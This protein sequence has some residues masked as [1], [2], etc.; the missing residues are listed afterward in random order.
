MLGGQKGDRAHVHFCDTRPDGVTVFAGFRR[1]G[2]DVQIELDVGAMLRQGLAIYK[3]AQG[4]LIPSTIG[5]EFSR[6]VNA[7]PTRTES[8]QNTDGIRIYLRPNQ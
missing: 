8:G 4:V 6:C 1:H 2:V 7:W 3:S 5:V